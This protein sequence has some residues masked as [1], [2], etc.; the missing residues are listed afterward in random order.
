LLQNNPNN[1]E[2]Q[3]HKRRGCVEMDF[4]INTAAGTRS[5]LRNILL[6][7]FT[8]TTLLT[9]QSGSKRF[10]EE[11]NQAYARGDYHAALQWYQ[12]IESMGYESSELYYNIGN[13]YYKLDEIGK[14]ILYYE[15]AR[16]LA[17]HDKEILENLQLANLKVAD[18]I[19][20]PP[21]FILFEWW[22]AFKSYLTL[23]QLTRLSAISYVLFI[24]LLILYIFL[25]P[26]RWR[27]VVL[28]LMIT[29][30]GAMLITSYLLYVNVQHENKN[31]EAVVLAPVVTVLSA[32]EENGTDVFVLHEGVKVRLDEQRGE[33]T[34]ISLPDGKNGW[35]KMETLGVI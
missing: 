25:R 2:S 19:E 4:K 12:R 21:R 23:S 9:A 27:K 29:A 7:L 16:K 22:D 14:A 11:G 3:F 6:F 17:P 10:F 26:P 8:I 32:P 24:L 20:M 15:R 30:A 33:W 13:C 5:R 34:K 35:L 18:R 31:K 28:I 1:D